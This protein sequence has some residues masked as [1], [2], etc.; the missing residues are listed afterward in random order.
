MFCLP[1]VPNKGG[2]TLHNLSALL[3]NPLLIGLYILSLLVATSYYTEYS[4]IEPFLKQVAGLSDGWITTT[5]MIFGGAGIIG[6][7]SFSKFYPKNSFRFMNTVLLGIAASLLLFRLSALLPATVIMLCAGWGIA[8]TAFNVA[9]QGEIINY[10][11]Q[12][13]TSI[14]M[15]IFSGIFNLG[16]ECGTL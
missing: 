7:F 2:F 3:K 14:S 11:P 5:L 8:V 16:G 12:N 1:K 4:H 6:S 9:L 13:A 10:S 15:S